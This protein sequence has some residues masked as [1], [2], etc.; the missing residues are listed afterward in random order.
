[1]SALLDVAGP[2]APPRRNGELVFATPW[3][4]RVFGVTM[5]L[6]AAGRFAWDEFRMRLVAEIGKAS[7]PY[8]ECWATAL[9]Q[10]LAAKGLCARADL[11]SRL[12]ELAMRPAGH[13]HGDGSIHDPEHDRT[14]RDP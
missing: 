2:G 8:W 4:S 10:L 7:A 5:A 1:V 13:D 3:E 6:H 14:G 9:E 11:E 12:A